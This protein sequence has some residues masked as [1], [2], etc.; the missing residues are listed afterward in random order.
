MTEVQG[1]E[2]EPALELNADE[3]LIRDRLRAWTED[4]RKFG[5]RDAA[6]PWELVDAAEYLTQAFDT[7][8]V[9]PHRSA[10]EADGVSFQ[11]FSVEFSGQTPDAPRFSVLVYY[12]SS[13]SEHE[14]REAALEPPEQRG[15]LNVALGLELVR[16]FS[17]ARLEAALRIVFAAGPE[18][19][20]HNFDPLLE[21]SRQSLGGLVLGAQLGAS[22]LVL[23]KLYESLPPAGAPVLGL[24]AFDE[25]AQELVTAPLL[26][27]SLRLGVSSGGA[28]AKVPGGLHLSGSATLISPRTGPAGGQPTAGES[29]ERAAVRIAKIRA[30]LSTWAHERP[31]NDQ[32]VTPLYGAVR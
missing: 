17:E 28:P 25:L 10:I 23:T 22:E 15:T 30:F 2:T 4:L 31:T 12:D 18:G 9:R 1:M 21:L 20:S 14:A 32:M 8:G 29:F 3:L 6:H 7:L 5:V 19:T 11:N 27:T 24:D 26:P 16:A 13:P